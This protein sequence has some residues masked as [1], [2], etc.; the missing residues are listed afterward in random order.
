MK[1]GKQHPQ[2]GWSGDRFSTQMRQTRTRA[3]ALVGRKPLL[4]L[5]EDGL[6]VV[7]RSFM[8]ALVESHKA[9]IRVRDEQGKLVEAIEEVEG[10]SNKRLPLTGVG[11]WIKDGRAV[12]RGPPPSRSR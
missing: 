2:Y 11:Y 9:V 8:R 7:E 3:I 12:K 6:L 1:Q 4:A 10:M 5:E